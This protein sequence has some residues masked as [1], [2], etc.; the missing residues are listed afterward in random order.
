MLNREILQFWSFDDYFECVQYEEILL[1]TR[2]C[3]NPTIHLCIISH[4]VDRCSHRGRLLLRTTRHSVGQRGQ[5]LCS[6][7]IAIVTNV[8][9][10]N[11]GRRS[12]GA[13]IGWEKLQTWLKL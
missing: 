3:T 6:N 8:V 13:F 2:P 11:Y 12:W 5:W 4:L 10:G 9:V 1:F 7:G